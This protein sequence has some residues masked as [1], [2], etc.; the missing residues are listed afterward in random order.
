MLLLC[1]CAFV[2]DFVSIIVSVLLKNQPPSADPSDP[3]VQQFE[4]L[5]VE[6]ILQI[7]RVKPCICTRVAVISW[8]AR[9]DGTSVMQFAFI[10]SDKTDTPPLRTYV[11]RFLAE[12]YKVRQILVV[13]M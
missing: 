5:W 3:G 4:G 6:S 12:W 2:P 13:A 8:G 11:D 1:L 9:P 10:D 7:T